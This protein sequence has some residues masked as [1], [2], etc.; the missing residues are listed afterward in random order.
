MDS[1]QTCAL[2]FTTPALLLFFSMFCGHT[3]A[4]GTHAGSETLARV[5]LQ[6]LA[7]T[8]EEQASEADVDR[9][10]DLYN[11]DVVYEHPKA[12]ARVAGK[13]A[14][15]DGVS[16]HLHETRNPELQVVQLI[17]G[18][19]FAVVEVAVKF[20]IHDGSK[21]L[22]L[23]RRQVIVLEMKGERIQRIIDHWDR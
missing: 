1:R 22:P 5:W 9:L 11:D 23:S 3:L 12:G 7:G 15:R 6:R 20:D 21:W 13:S 16:S 2:K 10:L 17:S 14:I 8:M 4:Q 19:N 18:D